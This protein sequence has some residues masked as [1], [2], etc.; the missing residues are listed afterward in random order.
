MLNFSG[1]YAVRTIA[2]FT[3]LDFLQELAAFVDLFSSLLEGFRRR[4]ALVL[5]TL[6][7]SE[8]AFVLVTGADPGL[9]PD[10]EFLFRR[11]G[12][13]QVPPQVIV[14]NRVTEMPAALPAS[15]HWRAELLARTGP[16]GAPVLAAMEQAHRMLTA[17]AERD[18]REIEHIRTGLGSACEVQSVP[19][20]DTDVHDLPSLDRLRRALFAL[21]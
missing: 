18:R 11:L 19:L 9:R 8:T 4:A 1:G 10:T 3:G 20:L 14:V 6:R 7:S 5:A 21:A 12:N 13:Q 16:D 2:R 15:D 17:L